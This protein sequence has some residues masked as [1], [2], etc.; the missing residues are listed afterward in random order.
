MRLRALLA[1]LVGSVL[2]ISGC[3]SSTPGSDRALGPTCPSGINCPTVLP[4]TDLK[5]EESHEN[6]DYFPPP[7]TDPVVSAD[8]A[9]NMA[10]DERGFGGTS[11]QAI[12]ANYRASHG[13]A[14]EIAVWIVRYTDYCLE[15]HGISP[16]GCEP[17]TLDAIFD[18]TT[19]DFLF[20][21]AY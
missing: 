12:Y 2:W 5:T 3:A 11:V 1:G 17:H 13:E 4:P 7:L 8:E 10:Y 16:S 6:V 20:S 14:K 15:P 19:G 18:A 9:L 21:F